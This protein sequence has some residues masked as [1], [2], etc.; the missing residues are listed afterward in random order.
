MG[1]RTRLREITIAPIGILDGVDD[2]H[3]SVAQRSGALVLAREMQRKFGGDT[4]ADFVGSVAAYR[5]RLAA[6]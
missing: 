6:F 3:E 2:H 5:A 1:E 4:A